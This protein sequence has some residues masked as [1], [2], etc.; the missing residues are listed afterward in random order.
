MKKTLERVLTIG[1]R[2]E[3]VMV[4]EVKLQEE[5]TLMMKTVREQFLN[6]YSTSISRKKRL[7]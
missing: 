2:T 1:I 5:L 6:L 7:I 4:M 3:T